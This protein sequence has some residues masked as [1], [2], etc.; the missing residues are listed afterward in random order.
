MSAQS[1]AVVGTD[2]HRSAS[3]AVAPRTVRSVIADVGALLGT[4]LADHRRTLDV[5]GVSR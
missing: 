3:A 4:R 5:R 1:K 2:V